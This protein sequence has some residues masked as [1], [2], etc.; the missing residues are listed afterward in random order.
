MGT[1]EIAGPRRFFFCKINGFRRCRLGCIEVCRVQEPFA[2][3]CRV[4]EKRPGG[5]HCLC[6]M[7]GAF[8]IFPVD[9]LAGIR[10]NRSAKFILSTAN[11]CCL[12]D[13]GA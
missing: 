8:R 9:M 11:V 10:Y 13:F 7:D 4:V 6:P 5:V 3:N 2:E 1:T 12:A